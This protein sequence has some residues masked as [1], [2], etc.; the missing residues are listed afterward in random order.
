MVRSQAIRVGVVAVT[1]ATLGVGGVLLANRLGRD[2]GPGLP[3][4]RA[5]PAFLNDPR[6]QGEEFRVNTAGGIGAMD[7]APADECGRF[8]GSTQSSCGEVE[9][10]EGPTIWVV[11]SAPGSGGC[12]P[13]YSVHVWRYVSGFAEW[14]EVLRAEDP[15]ARKWT[16]IGVAPA[17]LSGDGL[18]E[19]VVGFRYQGSGNDLGLEVIA[20]RRGNALPRVELRLDASKGSVVVHDGVLEVY[21]AEFPGHAP[22]CC[23]PYFQRYRVLYEGGDFVVEKAGKVPPDRV[24]PSML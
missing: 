23:P 10:K 9:M 21:G 22:N 14:E 4:E 13:A 5:T 2:E 12:C 17:D 1:T 11:D 3:E 6:L 24:P 19:L 7:G 8:Q 20:D 15:D 18:A 16:G